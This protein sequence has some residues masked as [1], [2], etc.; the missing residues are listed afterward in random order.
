M[1]M[2]RLFA[3]VLA[4]LLAVTPMTAQAA[5]LEDAAAS[6]AEQALGSSMDLSDLK[7]LVGDLNLE[8]LDL[9]NFDVNNV[10]IDK[11]IQSAKGSD[12]LK[13]L[14]VSSLNLDGALGLLQDTNL[15]KSF[16]LESINMD[17]LMNA[18]KDQRVSSTIQSLMA[19][20]AKGGSIADTVKALAKNADVTAMIRQI[21][22]KDLSAILGG[23]NSTNLTS[24]LT[25]G[26]SAIFSPKTAENS[27]TAGVVESLLQGGLN[28][29]LGR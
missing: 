25:Q 14:D 10:D 7:S 28:T 9:A 12:F 2:K 1:I 11:M 27:E 8:G 19:T 29:L 17:A 20:A 15:L 21:T 24:L 13:N 23:L 3:M 16:G 22:G 4:G 26:A 5:S 6:V 18:L